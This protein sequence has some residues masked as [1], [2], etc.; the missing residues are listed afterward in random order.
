LTGDLF[1]LEFQD[2]ADVASAENKGWAFVGG[3]AVAF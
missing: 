1:H 2:D 3:I